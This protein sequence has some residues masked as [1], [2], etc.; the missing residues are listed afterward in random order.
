M[1]KFRFILILT[2]ILIITMPRAQ[3][4]VAT[5]PFGVYEANAG[6]ISFAQTSYFNQIVQS[7]NLLQFDLTNTLAT[8]TGSQVTFTIAPH[9]TAMEV[10]IV[11]NTEAIGV[12]SGSF[13]SANWYTANHTLVVYSAPTTQ[14][15]VV[16]V[17]K[18]LTLNASGYGPD[19][20]GEVFATVNSVTYTVS[21]AP[22][23]LYLS[24]P[25]TVTYAF[26]SQIN[27]PGTTYS[28]VSVSGFTQTLQTGS[29]TFTDTGTLLGVY[30]ASG[31]GGGGATTTTSTTTSGTAGGGGGGPPPPFYS[32]TTQ[33]S[34]Q[35]STSQTGTATQ[36]TSTT[37]QLTTSTY[38][39][40]SGGMTLTG[41]QVYAVKNW[42]SFA[43]PLAG[44]LP[45]N[46]TLTFGQGGTSQSN[47][48][49]VLVIIIAAGLYIGKKRYEERGSIL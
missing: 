7:P 22:V 3:A 40:T 6:V 14:S 27:V 8:N 33:T 18:V 32:T 10:S 23:T 4:V 13:T 25:T 20:A 47:L 43:N 41:T 30:M 26:P 24:N 49:W 36:T 31:G 11:D 29:F 46:N 35:T 19:V 45:L 12:I 1:W 48:P 42:F 28:W 44:Y 21:Q 38:I 39:Y 9:T 2:I 37:Q 17:S 5:S 16:G 15:I 34:S